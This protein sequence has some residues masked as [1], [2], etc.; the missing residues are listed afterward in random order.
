MPPVSAESSI[1]VSIILAVYN[2]ETY[3]AEALDSIQAQTWPDWELIVIDDGSTDR[4]SATAQ[5]YAARDPRIVYVRQPQNQ[6]LVACLNEGLR[7]ARGQYVARL[8]ADDAMRPDRLEKQVAYLELHPEVGLLGSSIESIDD[9]GDTIAITHV[10]TDPDRLKRLLAKKNP[11]FHPSV[12]MRAATLKAVGDYSSVYPR[13]EDYEMWIR[14]AQ[15][16]RVANLA[17]PLTRYRTLSSSV[18]HATIR[19]QARDAFRLMLNAIAQGY[20]APTAI[21][22]LWRPLVY[23]LSP[24]WLVK[25]RFAYRMERDRKRGEYF[26]E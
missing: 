8:D 24:T 22:H 18:S 13:A 6:G 21:V 16:S 17:E 4:S 23:I 14:F 19:K 9:R 3:L 2:C 11:F 26:L 15:V 7:R 12:M 1:L 20:H 25:R 5:D 10:E